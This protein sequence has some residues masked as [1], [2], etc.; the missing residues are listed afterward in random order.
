MSAEKCIYLLR[1][2]V[3]DAN[4]LLHSPFGFCTFQTPFTNEEI[5][6]IYWIVIVITVK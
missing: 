6:N 3:V 2:K 5:V 1:V 4:A